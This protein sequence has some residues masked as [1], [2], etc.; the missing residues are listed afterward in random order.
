MR[1]YI[2]FIPFRKIYFNMRFT[3][4]IS[5]N[6]A[7]IFIHDVYRMYRDIARDLILFR[8]TWYESQR[9]R[10]DA[11]D[12]RPREMNYAI[13]IHGIR[14]VRGGLPM[15]VTPLYVRVISRPYRG[16]FTTA[17]GPRSV[18]GMSWSLLVKP[19]K[20]RTIL[21]PR[22]H[23]SRIRRIVFPTLIPWIF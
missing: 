12:G 21:L 8:H 18:L 7:V 4:K 14:G 23:R 10:L 2:N 1:P 11:I 6:F 20:A 22:D 5:L 15:I 3:I 19:G 13:G 9:W 17:L 16:R